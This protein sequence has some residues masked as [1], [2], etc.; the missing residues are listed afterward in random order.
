MINDPISD[1][2]ARIKNSFRI[3]KTEVIIPY[4]KLKESVAK[5]LTEE[6]FLTDIKKIKKGKKQYIRLT[7]KYHNNLPAISEITRISKPGRR[8][9]ANKKD[10]PKLTRGFGLLIISTSKG[11]MTN[12]KA[13]KIGV[14]GEVIC[15]VW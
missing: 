6:G 11:I 2:I 4:S 13:Q 10:I 3:Q 8:F 15:R 14:G 12:E 1:M 9:Y 5:I 7:L